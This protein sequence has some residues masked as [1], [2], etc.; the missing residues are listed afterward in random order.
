[1]QTQDQQNWQE[2]LATGIH[3]VE[4]WLTPG[5]ANTISALDAIQKTMGISGHVCE[6][7]IHH[8]KLFLLLSMLSRPN[9]KSLAI[10]LFSLQEFNV[11]NSGRGHLAIFKRHLQHF[12][13]DQSRIPILEKNS[14]DLT[15]EEIRSLVG[16]GIRL[17]SVDGGHTSDITQSDLQ[18]AEASLVP[19]GIIILDDCFNQAWPGVS[20]GLARHML[21]GK[22]SCVPFAIGENKVFFTHKDF[23]GRYR[24]MLQKS[25]LMARYMDQRFWGHEVSV[26]DFST[27]SILGIAVSPK[28]R[29]SPVWNF[30][31]RQ[32]VARYVKDKLIDRR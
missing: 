14:L 30:L 32:P 4:G 11:D 7:G 9:E 13:L 5:A 26:L 31:K 10:D 8:G 28:L 19:G 1:M 2:Y 3:Q 6:I 23:A 18:V 17:F 22:S 29:Q 15:G 27:Q 12:G 25:D 16:G 24:E 21:S 20:E